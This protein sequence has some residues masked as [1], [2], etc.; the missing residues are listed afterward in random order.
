[1][2]YIFVGGLTPS[3]SAAMDNL[4]FRIAS[5]IKKFVKAHNHHSRIQDEL[6]RQVMV[7]FEPLTTVQLIDL[8]LLSLNCIIF[9]Y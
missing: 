7:F 9:P 2:L 6:K 4:I 8:L 3:H 1:M 5:K